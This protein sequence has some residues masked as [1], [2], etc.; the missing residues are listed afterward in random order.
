MDPDPALVNVL[1]IV[2][3]EITYTSV[4]FAVHTV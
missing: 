1:V 4:L 3:P 2:E